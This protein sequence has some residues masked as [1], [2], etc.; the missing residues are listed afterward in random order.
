MWNMK[1]FLLLFIG[2]LWYFQG[3][4][5]IFAHPL[6]ISNTTFTLYE[7]TIEWVTYIHPVQLDR[8][9]V[10]QGNISPTEITVDTY[11]SLRWVLTKYLTETIVLE[12]NS[13]RC[14]LSNFAFQEWLMIDEIFTRGFP[15]SYTITCDELIESPIATIRFLTEV[16]LQ[17]N[18]LNIYRSLPGGNSE[19]IDYSILNLKKESLNISLFGK[20]GLKDTD[21][22]KLS[23]EDE[24][25]YGTDITN[26]DSD[27]DGYS[28][29]SEIQNSWN[30]LSK[31]LGPGQKTYDWWTS[32]IQTQKDSQSLQDVSSVW[33]SVRFAQIL[34]N[35]RIYIDN[36]SSWSWFTWILFSVMGLGFLHALGP[37]HSKWILISQ[38][39]DKKIWFTHWILYSLLFSIVH[40]LD[41]ILVVIVSRFFF[42]YVDISVVLTYVQKLSIF[43]IIIIGI[44]LL[45]DSIRKYRWRILIEKEKNKNYLTLAI[46]TGLTPC[47]FGWSI[48]LMLLATGRS[49]LALPLLLSLWFGIFLCLLCITLV[50]TIFKRWIFQY[51]PKIWSISP[52]FSSGFILII[53]LSLFIQNF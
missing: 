40:I 12:N 26:R 27:N 51:A 45:R 31:E 17:T 29:L 30:P 42:A 44:Y 50:V 2:L 37:G 25:I 49:D 28:D 23:D 13:K 11:Y 21:G 18:K 19:K 53:G 5:G 38:I 9:L 16:P 34:K 48:F 24:L 10:T 35:I 22:D 32:E 14:S 20:K 7:K 1:R 52:I 33:G 46:I 15:I 3:I 6:D 43:L 4:V 39:L 36:T 41:I 8:I 47:A